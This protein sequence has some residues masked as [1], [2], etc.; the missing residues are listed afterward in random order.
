[1]A[2]RN[3]AVRALQLLVL[4]A[5]MACR[6]QAADAPP[7]I[8]RISS[9]L[10][11]ELTQ[12]AP[13]PAEGNRASDVAGADGT[14]GARGG[15]WILENPVVTCFPRYG[16]HSRSWW[17]TFLRW[18]PD[19]RQIFVTQGP[20]LHAAGADGTS[21]RTIARGPVDQLQVLSTMIPFDV[22]PDGKQALIAV[23]THPRPAV[24][25][26]DQPDGYGRPLGREEYSLYGKY[27]YELAQVDLG[28]GHQTG[29]GVMDP[30]GEL[31]NR[32]APRRLTFNPV[33]DG[34][35][36][37]APDGRRVAFLQGLISGSEYYDGA[38][39]LV[40]LAPDGGDPRVLV[41]HDGDESQTGLAMQPPVWSPDGRRLAFAAASGRTRVGLYTVPVDG[42]RPRRLRFLRP[43]AATVSA[44]AW[45]PNGRRLAFASVEDGV[46]AL[47]S[48]AVDGSDRRRI[49]AIRAWE[50]S[51][52]P[53]WNALS[54]RRFGKI[55]DVAWSPDGTKLLFTYGA[56]VCVVTLDGVLI[57]QATHHSDD[58]SSACLAPDR[59]Q[60]SGDWN[61]KYE[62]VAAWSPRGDR[63]AFAFA[64][65]DLFHYE[66]SRD[67][68]LRLYTMAPDGS[69][70]QTVA[71]SG[72]EGRLMPGISGREDVA[73]SRAA[74]A[75][76]TVVAQPGAEP[77]LVRDCQALIDLR[78][79]LLGERRSMANWGSGT[80][81]DQ[82]IGV[83]VAGTPP[84]VTAISLSGHSLRGTIPP[85][86]VDLTHL[87]TLDLSRNAFA[88]P[89]PG[90]LGRLV[91]LTH[92]D[93]SHNQLTGP[94]PPSLAQASNLTYLD[95]S[96]NQ[97]RGPIPS[98][99][100]QL[101]Y[102]S[103]L[104]LA[105]NALSGPIPAALSQL[106]RLE[107]LILSDNQLTGPIPAEIGTLAGLRQVSL[108][109]NQF[110][111]QF[112]G[113]IPPGLRKA[114]DHD[115]DSL[116]LLVCE[117]VT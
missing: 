47:F 9:T 26:G 34:Y 116:R 62:A 21:V 67:V 88:G 15:E 13:V 23:C 68:E 84:R 33:F 109:G 87:R 16:I 63:I 3:A 81:I 90:E 2:H 104:W 8:Q 111:N 18:S 75:A 72:L 50:P 55:A 114:R 95:L 99:L 85:R 112:T 79:A 108:A 92:L 76:G 43:L 117:A 65:A 25:Q 24:G 28:N 27:G 54:P 42:A 115:L 82:W 83:T 96:D 93:L 91:A 36:A 77:G 37:W 38:R 44:P 113:C 11:P 5:L 60:K 102:L 94:I 97:L 7:R 106:L 19:V 48:I 39:R 100:G 20:V 40:T 70:V 29:P 69:D 105:R 56:A 61:S 52:G 12:T 73:T 35:P 45:W 4:L 17:K 107:R 6:P 110:T 46:L 10:R 51:G 41:T 53:R 66:D 58:P 64:V 74:C 98:E 49:A 89:I 14:A 22:T 1:M 59:P 101:I 30:D 78:A 86:L 103:D 57:G 32:G 31:G 71:R 80:P